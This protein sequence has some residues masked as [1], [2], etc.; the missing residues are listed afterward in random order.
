MKIYREP[1]KRDT[2]KTLYIL[3]EPTTGLHFHDIAPLLDALLTERHDRFKLIPSSSTRL[4]AIVRHISMSKQLVVVA[5]AAVALTLAFAISGQQTFVVGVTNNTTTPAQGIAAGEDGLAHVHVGAA[6]VPQGHLQVEC[7]SGSWRS[8]PASGNAQR[9]NCYPSGG[10]GDAFDVTFKARLANGADGNAVYHSGTVTIDCSSSNKQ[11]SV[12][13][14]SADFTLT[15]S[16]T[17]ITASNV[18]C[19]YPTA[20]RWYRGR[21]CPRELS[22]RECMELIDG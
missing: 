8:V 6:Y 14:T 7:G 4:E 18:I 15:G 16:G 12:A 13:A 11:A 20:K 10:G 3:D 9:V 5:A 2:G 21:P 22:M 17:S 19:H 1:S